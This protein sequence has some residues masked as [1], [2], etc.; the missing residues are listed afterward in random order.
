MIEDTFEGVTIEQKYNGQAG[1]DAVKAKKPDIILLDLL[2][3]VL[4]GE[5]FLGVLRDE[6]KIKDIPVVVCSVNQPLAN[7]LLKKKYVEAV[8]PKIFPHKDFVKVFTQFLD[9]KPKPGA[10]G[11]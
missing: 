4:D 5:G 6:M 10:P 2:M 7:K 9:I 1:V 3:P 8:L 11:V